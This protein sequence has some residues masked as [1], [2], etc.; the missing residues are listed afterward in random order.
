MPI[1][2]SNAIDILKIIKTIV[3]RPGLLHLY[4][5]DTDSVIIGNTGTSVKIADVLA[6]LSQ[7]RQDSVIRNIKYDS[8]LRAHKIVYDN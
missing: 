4:I 8:D 1:K 7:C 5:N 2:V 6:A 3:D